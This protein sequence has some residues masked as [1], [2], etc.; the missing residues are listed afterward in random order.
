MSHFIGPLVRA[1]YNAVVLDL[2]AHGQSG[3]EQTTLPEM[4]T[5][6][7]EV[8]EKVKP[9]EAIVAHSLGATASLLAHAR[10]LPLKKL[11]LIA[12]PS[13]VPFY[14]HG[15]VKR[16]GLP[17]DL[18]QGML[19]RL[20]RRFGDLEQFNVLRA[21]PDLT[22]Q[23]LVLHAVGDRE[24]PFEQGEAIAQAWPGA[25]LEVLT[26]G[27]PTHGTNHHWPLRDERVVEGIVSW[28]QNPS[29]SGEGA[30]R[31]ASGRVRASRMHPVT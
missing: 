6:I 8:A 9:V 5:A 14:V 31:E 1:G 28:L 11:A 2:P 26:R 15:F 25:Q 22:A 24:V 30:Q 21:A 10:G 7:A 13:N 23:G 20:R 19:E 17:Y 4:A 16:L 18:G 12:P 3:G 29:P 27:G